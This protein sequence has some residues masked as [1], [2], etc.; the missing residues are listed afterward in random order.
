MWVVCFLC[1][2][3]GMKPL[4]SKKSETLVRLGFA[5]KT[6]HDDRCAHIMNTIYAVNL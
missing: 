2:L 4:F 6:Y 3:C 5:C 1:T